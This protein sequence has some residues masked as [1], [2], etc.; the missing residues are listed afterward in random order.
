MKKLTPM[1]RV[2][3]IAWYKAKR[4]LGT[5]KTKAREMGITPQA[6]AQCIFNMRVAERDYITKRKRESE[7]RRNLRDKVPY[8]K[9]I[10]FKRL[11]F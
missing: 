11:P 1:Q 4:A 7:A 3:A 9:K 8:L 2:E 10:D 5:Y 6:L